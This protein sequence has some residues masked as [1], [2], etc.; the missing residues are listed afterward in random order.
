MSWFLDT[1]LGYVMTD[2]I[3]VEFRKLKTL[4][5][6]KPAPIGR[7][8]TGTP[9]A[10]LATTNA[11]SASTLPTS[12]SGLSTLSGSPSH[13]DFSTLRTIHTTYLERLITGTLLS[14]PALTAL[15]RSILEVCE[16][17]VAQVERWGGDVL[18]A[19]LF[20]GSLATGGNRVGEMVTERRGIVA[21]INDVRSSLYI[22]RTF[23]HD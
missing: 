15:I 7:Q 17:F 1:L 23:S 6:N 4:L 20:E 19:L 9:S 21:E 18:P 22:A 14:N 3:D 2:V 13:L 11:Q 8:A 5:S 16:R 10:D 12:H